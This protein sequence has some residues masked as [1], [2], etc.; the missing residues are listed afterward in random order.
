MLQPA[1]LPRGPK[2][3]NAELAARLGTAAP[4]EPA[5]KEESGEQWKDRSADYR[6][7][8]AMFH[9]VYTLMYCYGVNF[10]MQVYH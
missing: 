2:D 9:S 10:C 4:R 3:F 8:V 6:S 1:A 7:M 5:D